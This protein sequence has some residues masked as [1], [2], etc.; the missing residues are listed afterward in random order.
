[1]VV[2][3]SLSKSSLPNHIDGREHGQSIFFIKKLSQNYHLPHLITQ[4]GLL[5]SPK[6]GA[7]ALC[8]LVST[9][10]ACPATPVLHRAQFRQQCCRSPAAK[11]LLIHQEGGNTFY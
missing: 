2:V 8:V 7:C 6:Q 1:M 9:G 3:L 5:S 10:E 4:G 11:W